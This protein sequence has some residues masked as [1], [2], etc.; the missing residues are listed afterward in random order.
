M[1]RLFTRGAVALASVTIFIF[2][3]GASAAVP[4]V[5]LQNVNLACNDGTNLTTALDTAGVTALTNSV[6]A[7]ALY[8]AGDPALSCGVSPAAPTSGN[9]NGQQDMAV[10]GGQFL[11]TSRGPTCEMNF[12]ISAHSPDAEGPTP[13]SGGTANLSVPN[14]PACTSLASSGRLSEGGELVTKIDCLQVSGNTADFTSKVAKSTGTFADEGITVGQETAW[15]VKDLGNGQPPTDEI[16][17]NPLPYQS[18]PPSCTF[19]AQATPATFTID[20]GNITVKD[21]E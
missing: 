5:G 7:M 17:V 8:P 13:T 15:E 9:G 14:S 11:N 10:G 21:N 18:G 3:F 2:T 4:D 6:N 12:A 20:H 1:V 19:T 16:N